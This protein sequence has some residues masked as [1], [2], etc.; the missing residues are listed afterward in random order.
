MAATRAC[1]A[2]AW[3]AMFGFCSLMTPGCGG[4][5]GGGPRGGGTPAAAEPSEGQAEVRGLF[6]GVSDEKDVRTKW[7]EAAKVLERHGDTHWFYPPDVEGLAN[8]VRFDAAT[9]RVKEIAFNHGLAAE[10]PKLADFVK[11]YGKPDIESEH[12]HHS[13]WSRVVIFE[14][15]GV[16]LVVQKGD[17]AVLVENYVAPS[18][19]PVMTWPEKNPYTM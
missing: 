9:G 17:D 16:E 8:W 3:I 6:A 15:A 10:K 12:S 2:W 19:C 14:K 5:G 11:R 13:A 4:S 7:G 1:T 18:R